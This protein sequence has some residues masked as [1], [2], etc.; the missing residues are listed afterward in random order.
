MSAGDRAT[1][2]NKALALGLGCQDYTAPIQQP[3]EG[4]NEVQQPEEDEEQRPPVEEEPTGQEKPTVD[5]TGVLEALGRI[6]AAQ[7][8]QSQQLINLAIG[9]SELADKLTAAG[10]ALQ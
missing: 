6:E 2:S 5:L 7:A 3:A 4:E 1:V 9:V 8:A 10:A